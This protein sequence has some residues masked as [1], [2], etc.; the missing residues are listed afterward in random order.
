MRAGGR[1][2]AK[3]RGRARGDSIPVLGP[4]GRI[5]SAVPGRGRNHAGGLS[6]GCPV[7]FL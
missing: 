7:V 1:G 3:L 4:G 2:E 5:M 6:A